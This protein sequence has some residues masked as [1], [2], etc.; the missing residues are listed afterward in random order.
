MGAK[1]QAMGVLAL[2]RVDGSFRHG[3]F[4]FIKI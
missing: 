3:L 1:W 2:V 4:A